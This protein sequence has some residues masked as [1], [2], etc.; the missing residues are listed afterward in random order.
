MVGRGK[1]P[2]LSYLC[3]KSF[4]KRYREPR[5][6]EHTFIMDAD[7]NNAKFIDFVTVMLKLYGRSFRLKIVSV[8]D[9]FIHS[10]IVI[11]IN[12]IG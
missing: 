8:K 7:A 12:K 10:F 5:G 2:K 6:N 1:K 9:G 4:L 3:S 11:N